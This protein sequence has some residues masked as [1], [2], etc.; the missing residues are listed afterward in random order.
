MYTLDY[1]AIPNFL[2]IGMI[3]VLSLPL[4]RFGHLFRFRYWLAGWLVILVHA[5]LLIFDF[6]PANAPPTHSFLHYSMDAAVRATLSIASVLFV[7]AS[8]LPRRAKPYLPLL[9]AAPNLISVI[10][11]GLDI[12]A[13]PIYYALIVAGAILVMWAIRE[14][15]FPYTGPPLPGY[16]TIAAVYLVQAGLLAVVSLDIS[17]GWLLCWPYL[18]VACLFWV[19]AP[20]ITVGV[21]ITAISFILWGLVFPVGWLQDQYLPGLKIEMQVWNIPKFL[22]LSGMIL[23]LLEEQMT[24]MESLAMEDLLTG[25][26]NSRAFAQRFQQ[27]LQRAQRGGHRIALLAI[28]LNDFKTINDTLGH[29]AGDEVLQAVSTRLRKSIRVTDMLARTGGDE[30]AVI[31]EGPPDRS[32]A[33]KVVESLRGALTEPFPVSG[34][35]VEVDASFGL[36]LYPDD[37][38]DPSGLQ[39]VA[40]QQMYL[41]KAAWKERFPLSLETEVRK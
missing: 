10:C 30:F 41:H 28:D 26:P 18:L 4:L 39:V 25:L 34:R 33:N 19:N 1:G 22:A 8:G 36:A 40:D 38:R 3:V 31:V 12:T 11:W 7:C 21:I 23:T 29:L 14:G 24:K 5:L 13:R 32:A 17:Q 16:F 15:A 6:T 37:T 20:K 27:A 35:P 2:A 9:A